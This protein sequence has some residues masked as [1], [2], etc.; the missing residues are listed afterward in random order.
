MRL[1]DFDLNDVVKIAMHDAAM[2]LQMCQCAGG[3]ERSTECDGR[4]GVLESRVGLLIIKDR[5][6]SHGRHL[7]TIPTEANGVERARSGSVLNGAGL[8]VSA[9][10]LTWACTRGMVWSYMAQASLLDQVGDRRD[11]GPFAMREGKQTKIDQHRFSRN[12]R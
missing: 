4:Q 10:R 11:H 12:Y 7:L 1:K 8:Y 6:L 3:G 5:R 2:V 9:N